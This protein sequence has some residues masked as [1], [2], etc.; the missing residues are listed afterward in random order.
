ME[1]PKALKNMSAKDRKALDEFNR[2][3]SELKLNDENTSSDDKYTALQ[4]TPKSCQ[5][6]KHEKTFNNPKC[7][8]CERAAPDYYT[9]A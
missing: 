9:K 7:E 8:E 3:I 5:G 4:A 6:C 1:I 2:E